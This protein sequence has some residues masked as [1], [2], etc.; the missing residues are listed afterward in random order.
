[1]KKIQA[2]DFAGLRRISGL[3]VSPDGSRAVFTVQDTDLQQDCYHSHVCLWESNRTK[4][5]CEGSGAFFETAGTLLMPEARQEKTGYDRIFL[6][7]FHREKAFELPFAVSFLTQIG[8][9]IYLCGGKRSVSGEAENQDTEVLDELPFRF[10]GSGYINKKRTGLF[11][12]DIST[13]T[14]TLLTDPLFDLKGLNV[15]NDRSLAIFWGIRF[16]RIAPEKQILY[17]LNLSDM[18]YRP[19]TDDSMRIDGACFDG[20]RIFL[21]QT[22]DSVSALQLC[23][24]DPE[25]GKQ[26]VLK[27]DLDGGTPVTDVGPGNR[28]WHPQEGFYTCAMRDSLR[29]RYIRIFPDGSEK[30]LIDETDF[31]DAVAG[32]DNSLFYIGANRGETYDLYRKDSLGTRRLTDLNSDFMSSH[33]VA[34][35]EHFVFTDRDGCPVDGFALYPPDM[36]STAKYPAVLSVHGG[37]CD[38]YADVFC[39]EMQMLCAEGYIVIFCNPRGSNGKGHDFTQIHGDKYGVDDFHDLMDFTDFALKAIPGIDENRLGI[40]GGSYGGFMV[41]WTIG[42]TDRFKAAVSCRGTGD[43]LGGSLVSDVGYF[44][45]FA[46]L[47]TTPWQDPMAMWQHS[48]VAYADRVRTPVLFLHSDEDYRCP[49]PGTMEFFSGLL[50]HGVETRMILF[51]GE[52][53]NLS[54]TGK[55][56]LRKRRLEAITDW[57]NAHLKETGHAE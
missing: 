46:T 49:V 18:T 42:H 13:N 57:F 56:S 37:P 33:A 52:N 2:G 21:R 27:D 20:D 48:P 24:L 45:T 39:H 55:P 5:I 8:N 28:I 47:K 12:C 1:M 4:L 11:V 31:I 41:N 9:G 25:S 44:H 14:Q 19:L 17:L 54:R 15:N 36:N 34:Q 22:P 23:L 29:N 51:H 6:S 38:H 30:T 7:D 53:H 16:D 26:T 43:M 35:A 50:L 10:N 3:D 32:S 40:L